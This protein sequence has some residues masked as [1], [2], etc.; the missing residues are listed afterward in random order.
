MH[1]KSCRRSGSLDVN[2]VC[3][4][5]VDELEAAQELQLAIDGDQTAAA[6]LWRSIAD[7]SAGTASTLLWAR[8]VAR[9]LVAKVLDADLNPKQ[10]GAALK[11]SVGL[12]GR[13]DNHVSLRETIQILEGFDDLDGTPVT[14]SRLDMVKSLRKF[15]FFEDVSDVEAKKIVDYQ[16]TKIK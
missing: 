16:R 14:L 7:E 1:C 3:P 5:C 11:A 13:I 8:E 2:G 15:G 4:A 10:E 12:Q 6:T 9:Y